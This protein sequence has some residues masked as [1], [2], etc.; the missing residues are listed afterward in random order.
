MAV[1]TLWVDSDSY[2]LIRFINSVSVEKRVFIFSNW[3]SVFLVIFS[4]LLLF[5]LTISS[6]QPAN[7]HFV[8]A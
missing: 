2:N 7:V 8:D 3:W 5:V 1:A 6:Q 4:D